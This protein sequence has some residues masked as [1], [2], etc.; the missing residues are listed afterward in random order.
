MGNRPA[1]SRCL[2]PNSGNVILTDRMLRD[3]DCVRRSRGSMRHTI[4]SRLVVVVRARFLI[5]CECMHV[6]L[7]GWFRGERLE[8]ELKHVEEMLSSSAGDRMFE[9]V[10]TLKTMVKSTVHECTLYIEAVCGIRSWVFQRLVSSLRED[11]GGS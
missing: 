10:G 4:C 3:G 7:Y 11:R 9:W 6:V 8:Y 5:A 2:V 1:H